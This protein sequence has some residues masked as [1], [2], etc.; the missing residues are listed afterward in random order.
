MKDDAVKRIK[1]MYEKYMTL[2][3]KNR[4]HEFELNITPNTEK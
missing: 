4:F 1:A 2:Q 3:K